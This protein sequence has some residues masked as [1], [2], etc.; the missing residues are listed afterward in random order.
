MRGIHRRKNAII[1]KMSFAISTF[2][3]V[4]KSLCNNT[5]SV[6]TFRNMIAVI[7]G[8]M[9]YSLPSNLMDEH[10]FCCYEVN[11]FHEFND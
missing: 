1:D 11:D 2:R 5:C 3:S 9:N 6:C 7:Q 8:H 4:R 10:I